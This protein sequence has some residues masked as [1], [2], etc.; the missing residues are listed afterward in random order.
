[1]NNVQQKLCGTAII[2]ISDNG[3]FVKF[4][5]VRDMQLHVCKKVNDCD[6][7]TK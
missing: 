4:Q 7:S 6:T 1:M 3:V 5:N 2:Q